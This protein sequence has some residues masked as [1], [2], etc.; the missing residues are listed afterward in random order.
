MIPTSRSLL[1]AAAILIA[2]LIADIWPLLNS[3][4]IALAVLFALTL[5]VDAVRLLLLPTLKIERFIDSNIPVNEWIKVT[6]RLSADQGPAQ[7]LLVHDIHDTVFHSQ[8]LPRQ[9]DLPAG[10]CVEFNYQ[11]KSSSRGHFCL[12]ATEY[13]VYS[14]WQFWTQKRRTSNLTEVKVQPNYQSVANLSLLGDEQRIATTGIRQQRRRGEGTEF[15]Q[16]REYRNGDPMRKVDWKAS[17]RVN[18]L[19][20]KEFRDEQDQQLVFLLDTG[21]RMRHKDKSSAFMDDTINAMLLL[22]HSASQQGDAVGFMAFGNSDHWCPAEKHKLMIK[23]LVDHCF[24]IQA[25]LVH[26]D[27][28]LAAKRILELQK[29]RALIMIL[30]NTR[31][32]DNEDLKKAIVLLRK[33]H[34]I[35]VAD[36]QEGFFQ[37]SKDDSC[38]NHDEAMSYLASSDYLYRRQEMQ[39]SIV[40]LGAIYLNCTAKDLP[41]QLIATYNQVKHSGRL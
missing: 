36:L 32:E 35:V 38:N 23:H 11:L 37:N 33:R 19:I 1:L 12:P 14:P 8:D 3:V 34:L 15:H 9:V 29:R 13:L 31:D 30:T 24:D 6:L 7:R 2:G 40:A 41:G 39:K 17:S 25:G 16:L 28:L 22:S 10:H 27:Y 26:S 18:K 20:S 21:R 4:V 5:L